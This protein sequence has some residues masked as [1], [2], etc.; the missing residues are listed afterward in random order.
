MQEGHVGARGDAKVDHLTALPRRPDH[1]GSRQTDQVARLGEARSDGERAMTDMP[2]PGGPI[3]TDEAASLQRGQQPMAGRHGKPRVTRQ[4]RK[5]DA[6]RGGKLFQQQQGALDRPDRV[7][8][9]VSAAFARFTH[10][11]TNSS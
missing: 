10:R 5:V 11:A 2:L 8:V 4:L 3:V 7:Q 6:P 9:G 1:D